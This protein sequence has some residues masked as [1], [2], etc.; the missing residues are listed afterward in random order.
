MVSVT[1]E[2]LFPSNRYARAGNRSRSS[3]WKRA[4]LLSQVPRAATLGTVALLS[5]VIL[6]YD[7][8]R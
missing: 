4:A 5:S 8:L 2:Y 3:A 6:T 1:D 7:K